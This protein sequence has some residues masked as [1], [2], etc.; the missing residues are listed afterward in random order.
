MAPV[1]GKVT[2]NGQPIKSGNIMTLPS[3]GGRGAA[4]P[5]G[6]DGS[7]E[8]KTGTDMGALIGTHKVAV[9]AYEGTGKSGPEAG[10]GKLLVPDRYINPETSDLSIDVKAGE[11]NS[12]TLDLKS[13]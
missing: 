10:V 9:V 1:K 3:N 5:I 11:A 8:L 13:P 12:P 6:P 7:F 4:A 2:L